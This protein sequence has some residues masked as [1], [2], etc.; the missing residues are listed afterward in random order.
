MIGSL[1]EWPCREAGK[2]KKLSL[3]GKIEIFR[4]VTIEDGRSEDQTAPQKGIIP[5]SY[6]R[7]L[8]LIRWKIYFA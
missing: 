8:P 7:I 6:L 2:H 3:P 1:G 5:F 4:F